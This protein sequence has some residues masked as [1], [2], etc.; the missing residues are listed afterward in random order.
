MD[1]QNKLEV[2]GE[3]EDVD[4]HWAKFKITITV[5]AMEWMPRVDRKIEQ[6]WMIEDILDLMGKKRQAKINMEK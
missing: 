1:V 2:L 4:Q 3:A 5:A 6:K